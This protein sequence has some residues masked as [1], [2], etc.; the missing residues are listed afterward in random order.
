MRKAGQQRTA[1]GERRWLYYLAVSLLLNLALVAIWREADAIARPWVPF[2]TRFPARKPGAAHS[3]ASLAQ[4]DRPNLADIGFHWSQ[5]ESDDYRQYVANL[6]GI[7]CPEGTIADIIRADVEGL[8]VARWKQ[9][10]RVPPTK[11]YEGRRARM[12]IERAQHLQFL[13]LA[14]ERRALLTELIGSDVDAATM[15]LWHHEEILP[16]IFGFLE[17]PK[18]IQTASVFA[19]I[20]HHIGWIDTRGPKTPTDAAEIET[21]IDNA[22]RKAQAN[23]PAADADELARRCMAVFHLMEDHDGLKNFRFTGPEFRELMGFHFMYLKP[24]LREAAWDREAFDKDAAERYKNVDA[25]MQQYLGPQ[26]FAEWKRCS[27][28][29]YVEEADFLEQ[30]KLNPSMA[31]ALYD[32]RLASIKA[33]SE[34]MQ[35]AAMDED[36]KARAIEAIASEARVAATRLLGAQA[37][38]QY[39]KGTGGW[40]T[41]LASASNSGGPR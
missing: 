13:E 9:A 3:S 24:W 22:M 14:G 20:Q 35:S 19:G 38:D 1:S 4:A 25:A 18:A 40:I 27:D 7:G 33:A 26:R 5:I 2:T 36:Q 16:L 10:R 28:E 30:N 6:R 41:N 34:V 21:I 8:Y 37:F 23:L 12:R 17:E 29:R 15:Q 39:T 32:T 31:D 11:L